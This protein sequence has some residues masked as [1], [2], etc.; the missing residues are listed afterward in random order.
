MPSRVVGKYIGLR[1][2]H[3]LYL[4]VFV[5][6]S[7]SQQRASTKRS[8]LATHTP[9]TLFEAWFGRA[10][11]RRPSRHRGCG[12]AQPVGATTATRP[13]PAKFLPSAKVSAVRRLQAG[14]LVGP[15]RP[16]GSPVLLHSISRE[17]PL[18]CVF[19]GQVMPIALRRAVAKV[20]TA[21][22]GGL[23]AA[24]GR[25]RAGVRSPSY[26]D[27]STFRAATCCQYCTRF[28]GPHSHQITC[29]RYFTG[30]RSPPPHHTL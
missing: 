6:R 3:Q 4:N 12:S 22:H 23:C 26:S 14:H 27:G 13:R 24:C 1:L 20:S 19:I 21:K 15:E 2:T 8:Q 9:R 17:G 18:S 25:R 5:V 11:V 28:S 30:S 29:C 16:R 10:S 7:P